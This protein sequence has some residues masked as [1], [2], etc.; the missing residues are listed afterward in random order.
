[1]TSTITAGTVVKVFFGSAI[2][3]GHEHYVAQVNGFQAGHIGLYDLTWLESVP[4]Y[5]QRGERDL[6]EAERVSLI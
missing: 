6:I 4:T 5:M 3:G 1:M 2:A